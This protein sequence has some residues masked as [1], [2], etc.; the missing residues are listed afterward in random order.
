M[1][2]IFKKNQTK[3]FSLE[4]FSSI[5][6]IL[7]DGIGDLVYW[8]PILRFIAKSNP[9]ATIYYPSEFKKLDVLCGS[10]QLIAKK[11]EYLDNKN[12]SHIEF[13]LL[14]SDDSNL[15]NNYRD[16]LNKTPIR[17][18]LAGGRH[19][20]KF[21]THFV[22]KPLL[23]FGKHELIRN[24]RI[25][26]LFDQYKD[27]YRDLTITVSGASSN[28]L[29]Y[30]PYVVIH[31][32]SRGHGREWSPDYYLTLIR[33]FINIGL[34]IVITGTDKERQS[35]N[36]LLK[37]ILEDNSRV[38]NLAG[39]LQ[40]DDLLHILKNAKLTIASSTGPLHLSA[41]LGANSIGIYAPRRGL[42]PKRWGPIGENSFAISY[43]KCRIKRCDNSNC[44]CMSKVSPEQV[45]NFSL[46][47]F[48]KDYKIKERDFFEDQVSLWNFR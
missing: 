11:V 47:L 7:P 15:L 44:V 43:K 30:E 25:I 28:I 1:N 32:F 21:L 35:I 45:F 5:F 20:D 19:R 46:D 6:V 22:K 13:S 29:D 40:I 37:P 12:K 34:N 9:N 4:N 18:G 8:T 14:I 33:E 26:S 16:I 36:K 3:K 27:Y 38:F 17:L 23:N 31:P 2:L 48:F 41:A 39:N 24:E 10:T 42:N